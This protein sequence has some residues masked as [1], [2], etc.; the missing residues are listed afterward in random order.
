MTLREIR[1]RRPAPSEDVTGGALVRAP[2]LRPYGL[3]R[4]RVVRLRTLRPP[5]ADVTFI[6]AVE[7]FRTPRTGTGTPS[8]KR[9][10]RACRAETEMPAGGT[11]LCGD[12]PSP[13]SPSCVNVSAG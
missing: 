5:C 12:L 2:S 7:L 3:P 4:R 8:R 13:R 11:R 10:G 1:Q 6:V 9:P